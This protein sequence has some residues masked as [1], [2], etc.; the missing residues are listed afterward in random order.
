MLLLLAGTAEPELMQRAHNDSQQRKQGD[1]W[2]V[3]RGL[4]GERPAS[5]S[6]SVVGPRE[7]SPYERYLVSRS[8]FREAPGE[9]PV[10]SAAAQSTW[11]E[12]KPLI[13]LGTSEELVKCDD[14]GVRRNLRA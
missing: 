1:S 8:A 9:K 12:P 11:K 6:P 3:H 10:C 4:Q 13:D 14:V 5:S 7:R 2:L